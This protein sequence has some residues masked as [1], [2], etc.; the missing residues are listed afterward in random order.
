M[1]PAELDCIADDLKN[2]FRFFLEED[3]DG[4]EVAELLSAE[5]QVVTFVNELGRELLQTF[6]DV[7]VDQAKAARKRCTCGRV[8]G[9]HRTT[10]WTRQTA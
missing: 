7:R 1:L 8:A 3:G 2:R 4:A 10:V 9:V 6:V 5:R